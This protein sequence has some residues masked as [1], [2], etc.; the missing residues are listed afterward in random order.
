VKKPVNTQK[1]HAYLKLLRIESWQ[2]WLFNFALGSVL[3]AL[4]QIERFVLVFV[5]FGLT[6][7]AVFIL[8]QIIDQKND[9]ENN[10]KKDLPIASGKVSPHAALTLFFTFTVIS[11]S[12]AF[13]TGLSI[14]LLLLLLLFLGIGYSTP[15]VSFKNRPIIDLVVCGV[16]S[17]VLP[18]LIGLQTSSQ[19]TLDFASPWIVRRYQDAL[20]TASPL[21]LIQAAGQVFQVVGDY[22]ADS[23]AGIN[24]FAVKYGK[25]ISLR[26]ASALIVLT[27]SLPIIYEL[28]NLSLTPYLHWYLVTLAVASPIILYLMHRLRD[29]S[30]D[31]FKS[32]RQVSNRLGGA[33]LVILFIYLLIV[34]IVLTSVA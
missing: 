2:G 16:G 29:A 14:F 17:G 25:K 22:H 13:I 6:T 4:P 5:A 15:P 19:L 7:S 1:T 20:L 34:R 28:L 27:L 23:T 11:L 31:T 33:V 18:F 8:N 26:L 24:T 30:E 9:R 10:L 12:I 21:F 3:F 32:L